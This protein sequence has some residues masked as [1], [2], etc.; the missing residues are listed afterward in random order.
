V[1][2]TVTVFG[3]ALLHDPPP[4]VQEEAGI[5]MTLVAVVVLAVIDPEQLVPNVA[6]LQV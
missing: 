3:S 6:P 5:V 1:K 2:D 4:P